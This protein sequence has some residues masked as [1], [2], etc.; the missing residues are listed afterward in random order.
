MNDNDTKSIKAVAMASEVLGIGNLKTALLGGT[1]IDTEENSGYTTKGGQMSALRRPEQVVS[2]P[3]SALM[4]YP[5]I[6][7]AEKENG[8]HT[9]MRIMGSLWINGFIPHSRGLI[10]PDNACGAGHAT[11]FKFGIVSLDQMFKSREDSVLASFCTFFKWYGGT[12]EDR[13]IP[14][15][16]SDDSCIGKNI[17]RGTVCSKWAIKPPS[18][19]YVVKIRGDSGSRDVLYLVGG[20]DE[21]LADDMDGLASNLHALFKSAKSLSSAAYKAGN[22]PNDVK[23]CDDLD[24]PLKVWYEYDEDDYSDAVKNH[25]LTKSRLLMKRL[26]RTLQGIIYIRNYFQYAKRFAK[27]KKV[28]DFNLKVSSTPSEVDIDVLIERYENIY[29]YARNLCRVYPEIGE[30]KIEE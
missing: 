7:Q 10:E 14:K 2:S 30:G 23:Y 12:D 26:N 4:V 15:E 17:K 13:I 19:R 11:M 16:A 24:N 8:G 18:I 9:D 1:I 25:D 29:Q 22:I 6:E 21:L 5:A 3:N 20:S 28:M 27:V